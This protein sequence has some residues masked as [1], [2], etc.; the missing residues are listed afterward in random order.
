M[1]TTTTTMTTM[2]TMTPTILSMKSKTRSPTTA[3][4]A[5]MT[6]LQSLACP[7]LRPKLAVNHLQLSSLLGNEQLDLF[8][9]LPLPQ[10]QR[11]LTLL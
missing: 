3:V 10:P 1:T 7:H 5:G 2:T 6:C 9:K 4:H 8:E 11:Q